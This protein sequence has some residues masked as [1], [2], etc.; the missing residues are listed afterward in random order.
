MRPEL[1][2][3]REGPRGTIVSPLVNYN[4]YHGYHIFSAGT[5][6]N[7][8]CNDAYVTDQTTLTCHN[9]G[10][11]DH[12]IP[13]CRLTGRSSYYTILWIITKSGTRVQ[14][15]QF[16]MLHFAC[17]YTLNLRGF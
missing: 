17:D 16:C 7:I 8:Q 3:I 2:E 6:V 15:G 1:A 5:I 12:P 10:T 11:W 13:R 14:L 4:G 9:N